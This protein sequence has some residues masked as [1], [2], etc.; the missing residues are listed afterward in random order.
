MATVVKLL[1]AKLCNVRVGDGV[2]PTEG[3]TRVAGLTKVGISFSA[4]DTDVVDFDNAGWDA[5][6]M[7]QRGVTLTLTGRIKTDGAGTQ[8]PG[9][10]AVE[11]L[12]LALA[13]ASV[14]N[15]R[16]EIPMG[17]GKLRTYS[18][19]CTV[20]LANQDGGPNDLMSWGATLKSY[21]AATVAT[22]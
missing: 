15:F 18:V 13:G 1:P 2:T 22:V 16:F 10:A 20:A 5:K 14:A 12:G 8:D 3:F 4:A 6:L 11:S 21:G 19:A 17:G 7:M 9:Q